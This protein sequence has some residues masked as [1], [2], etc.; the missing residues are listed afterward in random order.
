MAEAAVN[1]KALAEAKNKAVEA[2]IRILENFYSFLISFAFT[3]ATFRLLQVWQEDPEVGE[4][5][6]V[7]S[8]VLYFTFLMTLVPFY[9]GMNR[10]LY[11]SHV[12]RPL[13]KPNSRSSPLL[14]DIWA[15]LLMASLLFALG[16]FITDP[17][18]FFIF[19][20]FC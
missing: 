18:K 1:K 10:F 17:V 8:T 9:Q 16:R 5:S 12:V 11:A 20:L 6:K 4:V 2:N 13:E 19:G 14:F 7:G 15:F 3:H